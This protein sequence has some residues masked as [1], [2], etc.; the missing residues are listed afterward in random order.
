MTSTV[1][2]DLERTLAS[3]SDAEKLEL[4][5]HLARSVRGTSALSTAGAPRP[6]WHEFLNEMTQLPVV[7]AADGWSARDHDQVIY[8]SA[9]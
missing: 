7:N 9:Q 2:I 5:E 6:S 8:G 1:R 3:L 4:I